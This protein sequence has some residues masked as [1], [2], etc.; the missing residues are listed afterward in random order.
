MLE[1]EPRA[2]WRS[3]S[4]HLGSAVERSPRS[5]LDGCRESVGRL[6][7]AQ[8]SRIKGAAGRRLTLEKPSQ[9]ARAREEEQTETEGGWR[10]WSGGGAGAVLMLHFIALYC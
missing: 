4:P 5:R 10:W 9:A 2:A 6:R 8:M 1:L 7:H 3:P